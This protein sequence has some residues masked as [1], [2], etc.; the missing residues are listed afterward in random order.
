MPLGTEIGLGL[1]DIVLDGDLDLPS[2]KGHR[3]ANF[4]PMSV[5]AKR[6]DRLMIP[7]GT[8]VGL[9]PGDFVFDTDPATPE[10]G[11]T[12]THPIFGRCL[13]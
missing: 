2:L 5:V 10:K 8:E 3:P 11:H 13:L 4:R 12:H 6:Q 7:L 9:G 1:R